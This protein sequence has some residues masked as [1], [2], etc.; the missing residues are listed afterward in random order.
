M[1]NA[2]VGKLTASIALD[3]SNLTKG[4]AKADQQLEQLSTSFQKS[5]KKVNSSLNSKTQFYYLCGGGVISVFTNIEI[6]IPRIVSQDLFS[7]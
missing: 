7:A 4:V 2:D 5:Q 1:A 3:V 6:I